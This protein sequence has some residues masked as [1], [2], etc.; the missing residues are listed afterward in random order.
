VLETTMDLLTRLAET[1][2]GYKALLDMSAL[3]LPF[4]LVVAAAVLAVSLLTLSNMPNPY[5]SILLGFF[6]GPF[7]V[8]VLTEIWHFMPTAEPAV[9]HERWW[10]T[11]L[12]PALLGPKI[13]D[14]GREGS[15]L[16]AAI[17]LAFVVAVFGSLAMIAQRYAL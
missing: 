17:L 10:L 5:F 15:P 2:G 3:D 8:V 12:V 1:P 9:F 4:P 16:G 6:C 11:A 14:W 7:L 13:F